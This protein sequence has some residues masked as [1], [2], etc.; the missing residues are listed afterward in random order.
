[1]GGGVVGRPDLAI[2]ES[3]DTATRAKITDATIQFHELLAHHVIISIIQA[4]IDQFARAAGVEFTR[5]EESRCLAKYRMRKNLLPAFH[6]M[7]F[8]RET[9]GPVPPPQARAQQGMLVG[10]TGGQSQ[11]MWP[12]ET[13]HAIQQR[14]IDDLARQLQAARIENDR[15]RQAIVPPL[16]LQKVTILLNENVPYVWQQLL[17]SAMKI[18]LE[19]HPDVDFSFTPC[20]ESFMGRP[21]TEDKD[22]TQQRSRHPRTSLRC[23]RATRNRASATGAANRAIGPEIARWRVKGSTCCPKDNSRLSPLTCHNQ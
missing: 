1:M 17:A 9:A 15:M 8:N 10:A 4:I 2:M 21:A 5:H 13:S 6:D 3:A 7:R 14:H 20:G 18:E 22:D 16:N 12:P 11:G 23:L 19:A